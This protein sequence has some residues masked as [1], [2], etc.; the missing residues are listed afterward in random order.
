MNNPLLITN[1]SFEAFE[2]TLNAIGWKVEIKWSLTPVWTP[3]HKY[4]YQIWPD[5][6]VP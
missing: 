4:F 2:A 1:L 5:K 6:Y 3:Y